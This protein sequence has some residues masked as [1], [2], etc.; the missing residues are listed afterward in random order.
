MTVA[1]WDSKDFA[2]SI[3]PICENKAVKDIQIIMPAQ[4]DIKEHKAPF[5]ITVQVLRGL[6]DFCV[7]DKSFELKEFDM[8]SLKADIAHS[9]FAK[10]DSILRLSLAKI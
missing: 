2:K 5:D 7:E 9:L 4:S 6:V 1:S 8:I 3:K 10:E